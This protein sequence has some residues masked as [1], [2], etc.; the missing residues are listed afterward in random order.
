MPLVI[1]PGISPYNAHKGTQ[2]NL[3]VLKSSMVFWVKDATVIVDGKFIDD[4]GNGKILT[5]ATTIIENDSIILPANDAD[6]IA[7]LNMINSY[8]LFYTNDSTPKTVLLSSLGFNVGD[9]LIYNKFEGKDLF[10]LNENSLAT[11][12]KV[13]Q[14]QF[15][16]NYESD[17]IQHNIFKDENYSYVTNKWI[18]ADEIGNNTLDISCN[19]FKGITGTYITVAGLLTTFTIEKH[20]TKT[21][22]LSLPTCT[23]NGRLD[24]ANNATISYTVIK[25]E[26]GT[27][28]AIYTF[29]EGS[30]SILYD[31][32]GRNHHGSIV[33]LG[34]N[35]VLAL[36]YPFELFDATGLLLVNSG[37]PSTFDS[38]NSSWALLAAERIEKF[39][40][41]DVPGAL[42]FKSLGQGN[43]AFAYIVVPTLARNY[44]FEI[45][46]RKVSSGAMSFSLGTALNTTNTNTIVLA[47]GY[48]YV[49]GT[50]LGS[51][52]NNFYMGWLAANNGAAHEVIIEDLKIFANEITNTNTEFIQNT[53]LNQYKLSVKFSQTNDL[54]AYDKS[55]SWYNIAN[56]AVKYLGYTD[57]L[58][59][60]YPATFNKFSNAKINRLSLAKYDFL[61][62]K[63]QVN[64]GSE[65]H[66]LTCALPFEPF[67]DPLG[68]AIYATGCDYDNASN[69]LFV[70]RYHY[71]P[72]GL[73][74]SLSANIG[75]FDKN[76]NLTLINVFEHIH[77]IQG[78]T[79]DALN[80]CLYVAGQT[81]SNGSTAPHGMVKVDMQGNLIKSYYGLFENPAK[82]DPGMIKVVG[83]LLYYKRN[84][85]TLIDIY[86]L[87]SETFTGTIQTNPALA[88]EGLGW[89]GSKLWCYDGAQ[90]DGI[91][92]FT[93]AGA[94]VATY[95]KPSCIDTESEGLAYVND[96]SIWLSL[97]KQT[98]KENRIVL[99]NLDY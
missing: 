75:I 34:A 61:K 73:A 90:S 70:S 89:D 56:N 50:F 60:I 12:K 83:N 58:T 25:E 85:G 53:G 78:V 57:L 31:I 14:L 76:L 88:G 27:V 63:N 22:N 30:G 36:G 24:I 54:L 1:G 28:W 81:P 18:V 39:N 46:I 72:A 55:F 42:T 13:S 47:D 7:A 20:S 9:G 92:S 37:N 17:Y 59:N 69:R 29:C 79:Y 48:N 2:L 66:V 5:A 49:R 77:H 68:G 40:V 19:C 16:H 33:S 86:N 41:T 64:F 43:N 15:N 11:K 6:I 35:W 71:T 80:N 94:Q 98:V 44:Y 45:V 96:R 8:Y 99:V 87:D 3:S 91:R 62:A 38:L 93:L 84:G 82:G 97:D 65:N 51:T 4:S 23:T 95:L 32:S 52:S 74:P 26:S 21:H 10:L 67:T